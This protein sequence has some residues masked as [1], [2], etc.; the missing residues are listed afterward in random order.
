MSINSA[1]YSCVFEKRSCAN[2]TLIQTSGSSADSLFHISVLSSTSSSLTISST[3]KISRTISHSCPQLKAEVSLSFHLYLL[4]TKRYHP[5]LTA[6]QEILQRHKQ[7]HKLEIL[8]QIINTENNFIA[9]TSRK[10]F[11]SVLCLWVITQC[12]PSYTELKR[13][14]ACF[15]VALFGPSNHKVYLRPPL[16]TWDTDGSVSIKCSGTHK[17]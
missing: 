17:I 4:L 6:F 11:Q 12:Y 14:M 7:I 9:F 16:E 8:Q 2:T 10:C 5:D 3:I 1:F 13:F 15:D